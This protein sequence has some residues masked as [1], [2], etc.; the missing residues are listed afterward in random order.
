M[1]L[2]APCA[3]LDNVGVVNEQRNVV[4]VWSDIGCPWASLALHVLRSAAAQQDVNLLIDHRAFP[5]ELFNRRPTPK[6]ILDVEIAA[7][8]ALVPEL[9][10]RNW[11]RDPASYAVT[12]LPAMAAVQAS[13]DPRI[14][15]LLA[16]DELD[17]ALRT[18]FYV[19]RK[20]ISIHAEILAAADQCPS[21]DLPALENAMATGAGYREVFAQQDTARSDHIQGSPHVFVAE[22]Y[23][24]HNPGVTYHWTAKP[25]IG[26]PRFERYD[27][28]WVDGVLGAVAARTAT[29]NSQMNTNHP[30]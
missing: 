16:S 5:L 29:P 3:D 1:N 14:G 27:R 9:G 20:C 8:A 18:A 22:Q 25:G 11:D 23:G 26:F 7:I 19:D 21:I 4:T 10:W 12:T 2:G 30:G 17:A 13:K 6:T 28:C 24:E 15:G